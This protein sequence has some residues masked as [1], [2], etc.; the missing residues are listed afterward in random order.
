MAVLLSML[1][2]VMLAVLGSQCAYAQSSTTTTTTTT[3]A[4]ATSA[5]P[6]AAAEAPRVYDTVVQV[7]FKS[8]K[9]NT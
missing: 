1:V 7:S 4:A 8:K 6:C 5:A 3:A 2:L 9:D